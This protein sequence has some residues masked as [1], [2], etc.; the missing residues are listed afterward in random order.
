[1]ILSSWL[2]S[3]NQRNGPELGSHLPKSAGMRNGLVEKYASSLFEFRDIRM[4]CPQNIDL[5][6]CSCANDTSWHAA[7][8]IFRDC[9]S[10]SGRKKI[11]YKKLSQPCFQMVTLL[12]SRAPE[13]VT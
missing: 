1:M 12:S 11:G 3:T 6:L 5:S 4:S 8:G 13:D 2:P 7:L 10:F 9:F